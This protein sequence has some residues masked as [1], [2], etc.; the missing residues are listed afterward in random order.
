VFA[1]AKQNFGVILI[2]YPASARAALSAAVPKLPSD[3]G[4]SLYSRF[5]V[6]EPGRVRV[7]FGPVFNVE[8]LDATELIGVVGHKR[9]FESTSV[10]C[11]EEIVCAYHRSTQFER[12]TD[13]RMV[14]GCF[15]WKVQYFY[16]PQILIEGGMILLPLRRYFDS[17]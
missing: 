16:V 10:R 13:L 4:E 17:E 12:S 2:R 11:N 8:I 6:L 3:S 1:A 15:V 5:A 7:L 9:E 14:E